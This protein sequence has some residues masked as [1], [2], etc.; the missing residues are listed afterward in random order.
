[1]KSLAPG[2]TA[3][4]PGRRN[5]NPGSEHWGPR[6]EE[7]LTFASPS[8]YTPCHCSQIE[9]G[10]PQ[11]LVCQGAG[12]SEAAGHPGNRKHREGEDT[13]AVHSDHKRAH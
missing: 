4:H 9:I 10:R 6:S 8:A 7:R 2:H 12:G 5:A 13:R 3:G 1:M 11:M